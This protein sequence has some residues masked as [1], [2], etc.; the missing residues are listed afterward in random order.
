MSTAELRAA[1]VGELGFEVWAWPGAAAGVLLLRGFPQ[2]AA[3]WGP[4]SERPAGGGLGSYAVEQRGY[5]PGARPAL[6]HAY[7]LPELR[8]DVP[9][10]HVP[11]RVAGSRVARRA[12]ECSYPVGRSSNQLFRG[13]GS[14]MSSARFRFDGR[15]AL[16]TGGSS[17]MGLA[18]ARRLLDEGARVIITGRARAGLD[19]AAAELDA[20]DRLDTVRGDVAD[21]A[22][23]DALVDTARARFGRLDVVFANAGT[24]LATV[25]SH[26]LAHNPRRDTPRL[27]N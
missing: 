4:V 1:P 15:T 21:P 14:V 3:S 17:G 24:A 16:V 19:A 20:G 23:L 13:K 26:C 2:S 7:G 12:P 22:D 5:S 10:R 8:G 9:A 11:A 6:V 25:D 27:S 18:T